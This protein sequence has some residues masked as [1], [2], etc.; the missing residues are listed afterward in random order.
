MRRVS[1]ERW[2]QLFCA[3]DLLDGDLIGLDDLLFP[4]GGNFPA[5]PQTATVPVFDQAFQ[6]VST[7]ANG[8]P[9]SAEHSYAAAVQQAKSRGGRKEPAAEELPALCTTRA[10]HA[11]YIQL[12]GMHHELRPGGVREP[13]AGV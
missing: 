2:M 7:D 4:D 1:R 6:S 11:N 13:Q 3:C 5:A 8:R 10:D 9:L 12:A